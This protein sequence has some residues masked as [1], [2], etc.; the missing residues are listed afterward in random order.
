VTLEI[1]PE[2]EPREREALLRALAELEAVAG[3][4]AAYRSAWRRAALE[5]MEDGDPYGD[6]TARRLKRP[7]ASR[8]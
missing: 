3:E 7:G 8:A 6:A 4:P 1:V 2:P 5:P